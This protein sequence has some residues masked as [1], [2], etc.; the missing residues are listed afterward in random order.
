VQEEVPAEREDVA[1]ALERAVARAP[2][3]FALLDDELRHLFVNDRLAAI[4]GLDP[5]EHLGRRPSE[6]DPG[7]G[8]EVE[9]LLA[10]VIASRTAVAGLELT[11]EMANA[12]GARR[13]VAT[14]Q[15][16]EPPAGDVPWVAGI[17]EEITDRARAEQERDE[18]AGRLDAIFDAA[19]VGLGLWDRELRFVRVNRALA[20]LN[21]VPVEAHPGRTIAEVLP[22]LEPKVVEVL[23]GVL[24]TGRPRVGVES[25]EAGRG[26]HGVVHWRASYFPVRTRDGEVLGVGAVVEDVTAQRRAADRLRAMQRISDAALA[27]LDLDE[28][29]D[30]LLRRVAEAAEAAAAASVLLVGDDGRGLHVR[31]TVASDAARAEARDDI[32]HVAAQAIETRRTAFG[33]EPV[34]GRPR[35]V[36]AVPLLARGAP[37]GALR[38]EALP[39]RRFGPADAELLE[40]A[41]ARVALAVEHARAYARERRIAATLQASLVPPSLPPTPGLDLAAVLRPAGDGYELGGDFYDVATLSGGRTAIVVGDVC[42]KGARAA[43]VTALARHTLRAALDGGDPAAALEALNTVLLREHG[44]A[45]PVAAAVAVLAPDDLGARLRVA[46]AGSSPPV[47]KPAAAPARTTGALG[48]LAGAV[49]HPLISVHEDRLSCGDLIVLHTDGLLDAAAPGRVRTL[50]DVAGDLDAPGA[51]TASDVARDLV[52]PALD[53]TQ[54]RPRDDIAVV[55]ARVLGRTAGSGQVRTVR[56]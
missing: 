43:A 46:L 8:A 34:A 42:G 40:L 29:L 13:W 1:E 49:A 33:S 26:P 47:V 5:G 12:P 28:L 27:T 38:V 36:V 14:F 44:G 55:V 16:V 19:P 21:G 56:R 54:G 15:P 9:R 30:E 3:G 20:E 51:R 45:A 24:R 25:T 32:R 2:F 10:G 35:A 48:T 37:V 17:V 4:N 23:D 39:G 22:G 18:A 11:G 41:A 53:G 50:A 7:F 31:S 52:A 6:L